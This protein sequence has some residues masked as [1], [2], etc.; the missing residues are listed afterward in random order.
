MQRLFL[1]E[2]ESDGNFN[3]RQSMIAQCGGIG[4]A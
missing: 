1:L 3:R 2:I 4:F